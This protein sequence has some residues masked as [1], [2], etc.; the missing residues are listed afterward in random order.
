MAFLIRN[1]LNTFRAIRSVQSVSQIRNFKMSAK[2]RSEQAMEEMKKKNPYF[3]KYADKL[4]A[5]QQTSP[6][7]FL[8]RLESVEAQKKPDKPEK[9]R[10]D[11]KRFFI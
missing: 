8:N 2:L 5:M 1:S 9:Q 6:E 10:F 4:A 3:E 7:E 11:F